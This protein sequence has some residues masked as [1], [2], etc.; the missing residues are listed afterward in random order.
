MSRQKNVI[1]PEAKALDK[2]HA[3]KEKADQLWG[4]GLP[5]DKFR[6]ITILKARN[7]ATAE[8][9]VQN[10][11]AYHW[12]QEY[13]PYGEF[14]EAVEQTGVSKSWAYYCMQAADMCRGLP[15]GGSLNLTSRQIRALGLLEKPVVEKYLKGGPL[16]DIPHDDV[17]EMSGSEL[18]AEVRKLREKVKRVE[19][20]SKEKIRQKDEQITNLE[21]EIKTG[22]P[23]TEKEKKE[24]AIKKELDELKT[25]LFAS[26]NQAR[27]GF[28]TALRVIA[29]AR[30]LEGVTFPMLKNWADAEYSEL[31][32]FNELFEQLDDDLVNIHVD[33]GDGKRA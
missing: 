16:G 29:T 7:A 23:L 19:D 14:L 12:M 15:P 11:R 13:L 24:K 21:L 30:Q 2:I 9:M 3:N 32:G 18:E 33:K 31:A 27:D 17:S 1:A 20:V 8:I 26:V 4:D 10:G 6:L 22:C 5:F 25:M 28:K